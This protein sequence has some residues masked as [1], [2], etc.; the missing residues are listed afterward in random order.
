MLYTYR[1]RI[2][3]GKYFYEMV[4]SQLNMKDRKVYLSNLTEEQRVLYTRYN[5]KVRQDKFKAN[6]ENKEKYN[7]IR[8]VYIAEKRKEL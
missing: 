8:K 2:M 1:I 3:D 5:N 7:K 4:N 6:N